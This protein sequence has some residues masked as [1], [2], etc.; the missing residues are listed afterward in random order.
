MP[1]VPAAA[2]APVL[3]LDHRS[4][5]VCGRFK[6]ELGKIIGDRRRQKDIPFR[7]ADENRNKFLPRSPILAPDGHAQGA[8]FQTIG[9]PGQTANADDP[10]ALDRDPKSGP[11]PF[12]HS[13]GRFL[14]RGGG[15]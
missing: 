12:P 11:P 1:W 2:G 14:R 3:R 8:E 7:L 9:M 4:G 15:S 13:R 6:P 10:R 5:D